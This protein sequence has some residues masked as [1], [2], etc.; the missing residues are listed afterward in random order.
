MQSRTSIIIMCVLRNTHVVVS[1]TKMLTVISQSSNPHPSVPEPGYDD[2]PGNGPPVCP[3]AIHRG[4]A[5]FTFVSPGLFE[6]LELVSGVNIER[7]DTYRQIY[8]SGEIHIKP[9]TEHLEVDMRVDIDIHYS[10]IGMM[11]EMKFQPSPQ[12]LA[13]Y[14]PSHMVE[15]SS[16]HPCIYIVATLYVNPAAHLEYLKIDAQSMKV[17]FHEGIS[18]DANILQVAVDAGSVS[19]P[20][21]DATKMHINPRRIEIYTGSGS[22]SGTYPLYDL[23][24]ITTHSGSISV[25]VD[26]QEASRSKPKPAVL[27]LHSMSGRVSVNTPMLAATNKSAM[28][29]TIPS[30]D[31]QTQISSGSGGLHATLIHGSR[32]TMTSSAGSV[33]AALSPQGPPEEE[34]YLYTKTQSGSTDI[35][36]LPSI[37]HPGK[38]MRQF[39]G[40]YR[41]L[42]GSLK[43]RYPEEWE[44]KVDGQTVTGSISVEW[45]G[46]RIVRRSVPTGRIPRSVIKGVKG[47]GDG[48]LRFEGVSGSVSLRGGG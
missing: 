21:G 38:P 18:L 11:R 48:T 45:P 15:I 31:Y 14:T 2:Q 36:V 42:S 40:D 32:T 44:G 27:E 12:S 24:K 20:S 29:S 33:T 39:Y 43:I 13:I 5:G 7:G 25:D 6:F 17:I 22:V 34:S 26:P 35:A 23:L 8:T 30:R 47:H 10:D 46:L 41:Y 1:F 16:S 9:S 28:A 3:S 19:F 37:S 4:S